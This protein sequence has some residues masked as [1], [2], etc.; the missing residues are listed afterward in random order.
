MHFMTANT[1]PKPMEVP[2]TNYPH[3]HL[4]WHESFKDTSSSS[5]SNCKIG[6]KKHPKMNLLRRWNCSESCRRLR[7]SIKN[8]N[9]S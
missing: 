4:H 8:R 6:M 3:G 2:H 7:G 1:Q 9:L 5:K